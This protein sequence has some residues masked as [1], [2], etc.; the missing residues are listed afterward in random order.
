MAIDT[1]E[2]T[3]LQSQQ[4]ISAE[5][6]HFL[7]VKCVDIKPAKLSE[8]LSAFANADGGELYIGIDENT[9]TNQRAWRGFQN[10]EEANG[11][12]QVF[13]RL[14]PLGTDFS[15]T[16]LRAPGRL[17][18][19]L[20]V[21]VQKSRD[22][23]VASNG[24]PYI[25]RGAQNLPV[26]APEA[27]KQLEY[28]KGITSF[29][30]DVLSLGHEV[31]SNSESIIKFM[32]SVIP[33]AEPVAWLAKQQMIR[34]GRPTVA[35]LL[36]FAEEPQ[37]LL[38]KRCG[39]KIYRYR[40]KDSAGSRDTLA[41]DPLTV[42]GN[43][44]TQIQSTVTQTAQIVE[45]TGRL[46]AEAIESITYPQETIH[47]IITNAVIH[48]DYSIADDI[49]IRIFDNRVEV[50]SP[51]GLPAHITEQNIL[52]ERFARN[53]T[54]VRIINKFPNPPNKD[55][56]EGLNTAFD[57]MRKLGLRPPVVK[58]L[59]NSVL[60]IIKHEP[61]A[62][63]ETL[64]LE[65]LESHETIK[66]KEARDLCHISGDYIIKG[67]FRKLMERE[68]IERPP[69]TQTSAIVYR[70]G[71]KFNLWKKELADEANGSGP[72]QSKPV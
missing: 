67:I 42:E 2:I 46:G 1:I 7:D 40:T 14:F 25:R 49:H 66:N 62:S 53:G 51:G 37:A 60:V 50:Q 11:H 8:S 55:V 72:V 45:D 31:I 47:E 30:T 69:G 21:D 68:L 64:I 35:G 63:P 3:D 26:T 28:A 24:T 22:I 17:G 44:Y 16:F 54:I 61:L 43:L 9:Q 58:N 59:G 6:T 33:E 36:L 56:G 38:P 27:R 13:E 29:E 32:L 15:Y 57:A 19:V 5:E 70:K 41:F 48:R 39:I 4:V 52:N 18:L 71:P 23:K 12:L 65:F 34:E 10:T 20:K